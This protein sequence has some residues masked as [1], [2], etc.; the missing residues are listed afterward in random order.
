MCPFPLGKSLN[1]WGSPSWELGRWIFP[2]LHIKRCHLVPV[3][4]GSAHPLSQLA[5]SQHVPSPSRPFPAPKFPSQESWCCSHLLF[6]RI[7]WL[8]SPAEP[9]MDTRAPSP[10]QLIPRLSCILPETLRFGKKKPHVNVG[11]SQIQLHPRFHLTS[12]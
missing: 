8:I 7:P 4:R 1:P 10:C 6:Y 5:E 11:M 3:S 9:G 2:T 12:W